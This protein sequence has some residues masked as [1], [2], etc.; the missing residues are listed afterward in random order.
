V[1]TDQLAG[2][3]AE[4]AE[5]AGLELV[6]CLQVRNGQVKPLGAGDSTMRPI[7]RESSPTETSGVG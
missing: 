4:T 5:W 3:F 6:A 2:P 1:R 7:E